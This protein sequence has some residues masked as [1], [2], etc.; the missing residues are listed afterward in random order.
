MRVPLVYHRHYS[1]MNNALIF[2]SDMYAESEKRSIVYTDGSCPGNPGPV[3]GVGIY[4]PHTGMALSWRIEDE[5]VTNNRAELLA[6][7]LAL[8][9]EDAGSVTIMTDSEYV[10]KNSVEN[11][12]RWH[13]NDYMGVAND[14][15]WRVMHALIYESKR[16]VYLE[17][18]RRGSNHGNV[19]SDAL[20]QGA[21]QNTDETYVWEY[22]HDLNRWMEK[23]PEQRARLLD[24][25]KQSVSGN[26][27][28]VVK[29]MSAKQTGATKKGSLGF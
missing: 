27:A 5:S 9:V 25:K 18:V 2:Y 11:L 3:G 12:S 26:S 16:F 4:I 6:T 19:V 8:M 17:H 10:S 13:G 22:K 24:T 23:N 28:P 1:L 7:I 21:S 15:L 20:A 29:Q 14:D